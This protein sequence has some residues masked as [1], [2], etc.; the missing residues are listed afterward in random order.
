MMKRMVIGNAKID[1][2]DMLEVWKRQPF[3]FLLFS[4]Y[5]WEQNELTV[6]DSD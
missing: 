3:L 5:V 6:L 4:L 1:E 2:I